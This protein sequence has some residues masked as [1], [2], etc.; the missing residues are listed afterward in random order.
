MLVAVHIIRAHS[1]PEHFRLPPTVATSDKRN[2]SC[3]SGALKTDFFPLGV[4]CLPPGCHNPEDKLWVLV[5]SGAL[6]G[7]F[8]LSPSEFLVHPPV[9]TGGKRTSRSS[10]FFLLVFCVPL[11]SQ[12]R[13]EIQPLFSL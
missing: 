12:A 9:A 8:S 2:F 11:L 3:Y 4:I 1:D 13:L 6:G 10:T 5:L 7:N